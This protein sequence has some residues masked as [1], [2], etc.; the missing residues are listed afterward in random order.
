MLRN[1]GRLKTFC[2]FEEFARSW[3]TW[4]LELPK[5]FH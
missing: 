5:S 4:R 1:L 2:F 3:N